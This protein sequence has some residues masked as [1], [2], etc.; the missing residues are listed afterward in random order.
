LPIC[1]TGWADDGGNKRGEA[2]VGKAR[3]GMTRN[4][5]VVALGEKEIITDLD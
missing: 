1:T 4:C 3:K 2:I 5:F